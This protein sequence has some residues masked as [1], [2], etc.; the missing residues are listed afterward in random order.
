MKELCS[1]ELDVELKTIA[2]TSI[3]FVMAA[4]AGYGSCLQARIKP[5][6]VGVGPVEAAVDVTRALTWLDDNADL[7]TLV[8]SLGSAGSSKLEQTSVYQV[9][10]VAYG[11]VLAR[12]GCYMPFLG[13]PT[14]VDLP[15]R[16]PGIPE[17]SLTTGANVILGH[18]HSNIPTDMVDME[19]YAVLRACQFYNLPLIG[20]RGILNGADEQR[21]ISAR[22]EFLKII[23]RNLA[24]ALDMV[25]AELANGHPLLRAQMFV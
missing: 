1:I 23:D 12:P 14:N 25:L 22:I 18:A 11:D 21:H 7:P 6:L 20:L 13:L 8:V 3:L 17:A 16:I 24:D 9:A 5:L 19:T 10:S 2:A 4:G 15:L